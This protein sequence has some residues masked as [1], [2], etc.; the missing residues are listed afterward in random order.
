MIQMNAQ[1]FYDQA[2]RWLLNYGPRVLTAIIILLVG[3][4]LI[5]LVKKW[6]GHHLLQRDVN[7]SIRP[8]LINV[9]VIFSQVLLIIG[10]MQIIGLPLIS[11]RFLILSVIACVYKKTEP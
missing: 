2:T 1:K 11:A 6:L 7:S 4:W 3:L 5:R 8:F 10:L 9:I